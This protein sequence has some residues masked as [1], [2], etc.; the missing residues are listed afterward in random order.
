MKEKK[1]PELKQEKK[2]AKK[3]K[4]TLKPEDKPI[5]AENKD[6][7]T[8]DE[9]EAIKEEILAHELFNPYALILYNYMRVSSYET[10]VQLVLSMRESLLKISKINDIILDELKQDMK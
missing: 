4:A 6:Q 5:I 1:A 8:I 2:V 10:N 3:R 9:I 7:P